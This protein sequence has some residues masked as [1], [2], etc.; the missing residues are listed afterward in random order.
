MAAR[1]HAN[2]AFRSRRSCHVEHHGIPTGRNAPGK[3][4]RAQP[5]IF[6][7]PGSHSLTCP[8]GVTT[9]KPDESFLSVVLS[10]LSKT[11]GVEKIPYRHKT[12]AVLAS[13]ADCQIG[14]P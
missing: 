1:L 8:R 10:V 4:I 5:I 13:L 3:G 2:F 12:N 9:H 11:P 6:P 7:S 14:R